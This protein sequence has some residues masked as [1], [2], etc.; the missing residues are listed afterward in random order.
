VASRTKVNDLDPV[1]KAHRI[2]KH[3]IFRFQ[4]SMDETETLQLCQRRQN[5]LCDR[6]DVLQ[7]QRLELIMLQKVVEVLFEHLK[8]ETHVVLVLEEF[9]RANKVILVRIFLTQAAQDVHLD[10]SLARVRRMILENLDRN[11]LA[12]PT[13]PALDDLSERSTPEKFQDFIG[14]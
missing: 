10:V 9:E 13:F 8:D 2:N 4:V 1:W 14:G 6:S 3:D 7:R 5:L 11:D 12:R